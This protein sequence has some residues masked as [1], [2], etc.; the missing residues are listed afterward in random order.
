M[1][2][3]GANGFV[4][5][6]ICRAVEATP[7]LALLRVV[8]G[9][10]ARAKLASSGVVIHAANPARRFRAESDPRNDFR[11]TAEKTFDLL[12]ASEGKK[13][14]LVSSISCRTQ[15]D[16]NYGR[17]RRC[18]ELLALGRGAVVVRL[19][20]M[21]GGD[22]KQ[23]S[24]HDLLAGRQVYVAAATRYAYVDVDW[25]GGK[26]VELINSESGIY[27][28]GARNAVSLGE[29]RD[30]CGSASAFSGPDDTQIPEP[31]TDGPDARLV[32]DF[33]QKELQTIDSWR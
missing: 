14:L 20:P 17:N 4:G 31:P 16:S 19:G 5:S 11:E 15:L 21:F 13:F 7:G 33:A 26:I 6:S 30:Q 32:F 8:R 12:S 24:I 23:D 3:V 27:E 18:C 2:V 29:I 22:R 28:V 1:A 10:N 25:A 9:D